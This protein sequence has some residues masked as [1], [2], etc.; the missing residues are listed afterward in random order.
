MSKWPI[1]AC[2]S[3]DFFLEIKNIFQI[4]TPDVTT[5][6]FVKK[7]NKISTKKLLKNFQK[8]FPIQELNLE[9]PTLQSIAPTTTMLLRHDKMC[10]EIIY[11]LV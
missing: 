7:I 3:R 4:L 8:K 6:F 9:P 2:Q 11:L 5:C 1:I 10:F